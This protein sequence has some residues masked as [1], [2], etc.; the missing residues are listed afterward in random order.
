M[1]SSFN[2]FGKSNKEFGNPSVPVWLGKPRA[3]PVGGTLS[4]GDLKAGAKYAAGTPVKLDGK[5]LKVFIGFVVTAFSA[6]DGSTTLNDTITI[7][8]Y[9]AGGATILPA[10]NDFIQKLGATFATTGKAAKV[11]SIAAGATEGTYDVAVAHSATVDTPQ[12]GDIITFSA[13]TAAGSGKSIAVIPDGYLYN[14]IY[15]GDIDVTAD[16]AGASGAV[17]K[18]HGEGILIKRTPAAPVAAQ[19]AAAVPGVLQVNY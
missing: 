9:V 19:M 17:I 18:Y 7:K 10:V 15:L 3:V 14:D 2:A 5:T 11:V 8:P 13:A 16:G 4:S 12:A 1:T 6:G